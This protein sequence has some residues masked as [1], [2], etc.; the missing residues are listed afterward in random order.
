MK[1]ANFE[2]PSR[3]LGGVRMR[4]RRLAAAIIHILFLLYFAAM[5]RFYS[6]TVTSRLVNIAGISWEIGNTLYWLITA[7]EEK[8]A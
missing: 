2:T 6:T 3:C 8:C 4:Y 5:L 7:W 1:A